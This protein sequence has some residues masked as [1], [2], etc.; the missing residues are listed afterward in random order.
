[1]RAFQDQLG[2][3]VVGTDNPD[4]WADQYREAA[5][6]AAESAREA[7]RYRCELPAGHKSLHRDGETTW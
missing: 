2:R 7:Q 1:M 6:I 3:G 5:A 4:H